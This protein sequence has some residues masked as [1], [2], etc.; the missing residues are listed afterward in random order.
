VIINTAKVEVEYAKATGQG[1]SEFL[2]PKPTLPSGITGVT[3]RQ[4][5]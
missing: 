4:I 2:T 5:R 3:R 1:G